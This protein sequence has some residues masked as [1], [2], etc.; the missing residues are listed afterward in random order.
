M[1]AAAFHKGF[2][3][4]AEAEPGFDHMGG[5]VKLR[6]F[7]AGF[8]LPNLWVALSIAKSFLFS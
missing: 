2:S 1:F 8:I 6:I 7:Y 3:F 4:I 5:E